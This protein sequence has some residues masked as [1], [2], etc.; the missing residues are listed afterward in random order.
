MLY[1]LCVQI[2]WDG[3]EE[4]E[5]ESY[6]GKSH[7]LSVY[8][9]SNKGMLVFISSIL[10]L[11][12]LTKSVHCA[13]RYL[14]DVGWCCLGLT[15]RIIFWLW[16]EF[17]WMLHYLPLILSLFLKS[18]RH[19]KKINSF[20]DVHRPMFYNL[21]VFRIVVDMRN[22]FIYLILMKVNEITFEWDNCT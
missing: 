22:A 8:S 16:I 13:L 6:P 21:S 5:L 1:V 7:L 2:I 14:F 10:F 3:D 19:C 11:I 18:F 17:H 4:K 9:T 20:S 15:W 12:L